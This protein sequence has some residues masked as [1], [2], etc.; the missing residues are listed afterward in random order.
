MHILKER[1]FDLKSSINQI[2]SHSGVIVPFSRIYH[3]R[4]F[5]TQRSSEKILVRFNVARR[6]KK[7]NPRKRLNK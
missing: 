2:I 4:E 3:F 6:K 5:V 1:H 7:M